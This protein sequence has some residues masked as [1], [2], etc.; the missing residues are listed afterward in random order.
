MRVMFIGYLAVIGSQLT[1][2]SQMTDLYHSAFP[3]GHTRYLTL[4][5]VEILLYV[6]LPG[7]Y[8][9]P[10]LV[11]M[12]L[13]RSWGYVPALAVSVISLPLGFCAHSLERL[14]VDLR[15][16]PTALLTQPTACFHVATGVAIIAAYVMARSLDEAP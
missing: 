12:A 8:P 15:C 1:W 11:R 4:K 10:A 2:A 13:R 14:V 7:L 6:G 9:L 16:E 5:P 3:T